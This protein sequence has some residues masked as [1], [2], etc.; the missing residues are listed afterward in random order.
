MRGSETR[1]AQALREV[2]R[3]EV[4]PALARAMTAFFLLLLATVPALEIA[5]DRKPGSGAPW[6]GL[7]AAALEASRAVRSG[8]L[9][10]N[11]QLL[12]A[13]TAFEGALEERSLVAERALPSVQSFLTR[14]LGAGNEQVILGRQGWLYFRPD[15]DYLAGRG[16]L[17][18]SSVGPQATGERAAASKRQA[19]PVRAIAGLA[20]QLAGRGIG[21]V[22]VPTPVKPAIHPEGL[23]PRL[24]QAV[25]LENPSFDR[26]VERLAEMEIPVYDPAPRLAESRRT[27]PWP[28]FL[29]TDT[30]WTP[31][32]MESA[33]EGL[34]EFLAR[35]VALP[36]R[37]P[38]TYTRQAA[39]VTG[40]GDLAAL[41]R[42]PSRARL[43]PPESVPTRQVLG[44]AGAPWSPDPEADVL[45]LGDS[46]SN[47]YSQPELGWGHAAGFA[48]QLSYFLGRPVDKIAV[49]AGGPAAAR[50]RLAVT[51]AAGED[52]LAGKRLVVHQF[53]ARELASGD[54]RLVE[55]GPGGTSE[56]TQWP[57]KAM[58]ATGF[59]AWESNRSGDWRIWTRRLEGSPPRRLSPDEPQRQHCCPHISPDGSQLVYL[60]RD[61][62]KDE[63]PDLEAAGE[64]KLLRI[65][66]TAQRTLAV[67]ARPYGW[68][69]RAAVW[70]GDRELIYVAG[71]G[72]TLLMDLVTGRSAPLT[73]ERRTK[74]AWLLDPTL[75]HAVDGSPTFSTYDAAAKRV[76]EGRRRQGCEPYFSH[77]GRYGYWVEGAGGPVRW[78]ELAG[79]RGGTLLDP[80]DAR[81]AT[82]QRYVYF[83]MLSRDGRMLTFG[84]SPGDHDHFKSNY[85]V[86]VA[87]VRAETPA[88]AGRPWRV[89]WH[90]ASDRYPDVHVER[91]DMDRWTEQAPPEPVALVAKATPPPAARALDASAVLLACSRVPSLRE[92]SPYRSALIVC[93]WE[94]DQASD[95]TPRGTRV[96][97]AHWALRDGERQR[98]A[99]AQPGAGARVSLEP[100][101]GTAQVE[102]YPIFN[103]LRSAPELPVHYA[104]EP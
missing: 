79:G 23:A 87:P 15:L 71:D 102:A 27:S 10:A 7:V 24:G 8:V 67:D 20:A 83:P 21:L 13:M 89:T 68:G 93:E 19:D 63:Y 84:A 54:W 32:A 47:V 49:N 34:A 75:R 40:R 22:V 45:V 96:R 82:A 58:P 11:R 18:P 80:D 99:S 81:L 41:L 74:L 69:N 30:H 56:A 77:D 1:E 28:L 42:L 55:L 95:G 50:E 9:L 3:T 73:T 98:I 51:L 66:G 53:A 60:S 52:R 4:G 31:Q 103:T 61:V 17:E 78:I 36:E 88:L 33:A 70:R 39:W 104:R 5:R 14:R 72:R 29:R 100:L 91:V 90:P 65:D 94:V 97:A 101:R 16:F 85:D 37:T 25:P 44:P 26:F 43:Y 38:L 46:F 12:D 35:H 6:R 76:L 86:F 59:V 57:G 64:L 62:P 48:E 2:G 92:I